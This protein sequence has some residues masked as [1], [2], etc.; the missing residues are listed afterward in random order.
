MLKGLKEDKLSCGLYCR[1]DIS[2]IFY[3]LDLVGICAGNIYDSFIVCDDFV[4]FFE[5]TLDGEYLGVRL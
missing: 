1:D 2:L 5:Y 3:A 4:V